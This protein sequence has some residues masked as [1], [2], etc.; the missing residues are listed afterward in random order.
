[1]SPLASTAS[2]RPP[3]MDEVEAVL[4]PPGMSVVAVPPVEYSTSPLELMPDVTSGPEGIALPLADVAAD[5]MHARERQPDN[6][7]ENVACP[8]LVRWG[9]SRSA[10]ASCEA[11]VVAACPTNE[12]M[13]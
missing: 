1:M 3:S 2:A 9:L 4:D 8:L 7:G 6:Y 13:N 10:M 5:A 12:S 11:V